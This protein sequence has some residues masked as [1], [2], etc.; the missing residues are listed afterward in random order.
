VR[1]RQILRTLVL[2]VCGLI[3]GVTV[4]SAQGDRTASDNSSQLLFVKYKSAKWFPVFPELGLGSPRMTIL[5]VDSRTHAT[6][7]L[8]RLPKNIHIPMHW[9]GANETQ[10]VLQGDFIVLCAGKKAVL[11]ALDFNYVPK[12]MPFEA[13]TKKDGALLFITVDGAWDMNWVN[14]PPTRADM[15]GGRKVRE[16]EE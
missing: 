15:L 16:E 12:K 13:W 14:G 11:E 2:A 4:L 6:Q 1:P 7:L 3:A 5:R 9:H 8:V 10:T